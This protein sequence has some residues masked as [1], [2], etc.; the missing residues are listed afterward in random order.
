MASDSKRGVAFAVILTGII[1]G[2]LGTYFL[3][4]APEQSFDFINTINIKLLLII[5]CDLLVLFV[6]LYIY[7][8]I[9]VP[10]PRKVLYRI[11]R[12]I[13]VVGTALTGAPLGVAAIVKQLKILHGD[14]VS[15]KGATHTAAFVF[16][17]MM[18]GL[19]L[20][21][22][23]YRNLAEFELKNGPLP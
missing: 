10:S 19:W 3:I 2:A 9:D 21:Y 16:I 11:M 8:R 18:L 7:N 13:I 15:F 6:G 23:E 12:T 4:V 17:S 5:T 1:V 14:D 22:R 20:L